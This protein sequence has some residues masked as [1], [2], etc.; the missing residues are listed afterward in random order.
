MIEAFASAFN[1]D[2]NQILN[3]FTSNGDGTY[4]GTK[5]KGDFAR[6]YMSD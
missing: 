2:I 3:N 4:K 6:A 1:Y 5:N